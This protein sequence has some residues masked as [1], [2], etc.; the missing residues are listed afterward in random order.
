MP[1]K[2]QTPSQ[3]EKVVWNAYYLGAVAHPTIQS[4]FAP[5]DRV[6]KGGSN[7][8]PAPQRLGRLCPPYVAYPA[9]VLQFFVRCSAPR[10][11]KA[12]IV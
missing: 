7:N 10:S 8:V 1:R 3:L 9:I 4:D 12:K 2:P 6:G 5:T 11:D